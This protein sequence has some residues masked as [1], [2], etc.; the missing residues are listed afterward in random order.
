MAKIRF[1]VIGVGN[2]GSM[3]AENLFSGKIKGAELAAVC[4]IDPEK[5]QKAAQQYGVLSFGDYREL[6]RSQAVDAVIVSVPH[7]LHPEI[8]I[9]AMKAGLHV[10]TE[11]P[12][13]VRVGDV[14]KMNREAA[15]HDTVFAIMFNQR[16]N[17]LFQKAKALV[18]SG[19]LGEKRRLTWIITNWYR[20]ES[21]YRSGSW[22]A[23]WRGEG[24]G[25]LMNQAPHN[26][27]LWQ[28]IFGMPR[29]IRAVVKEGRYHDITVEDYAAI[30]GDYDNGAEAQFITTTGEYPGTNRLEIVLSR[31]KIVIEEGKL[32]CWRLSEDADAVSKS[33]PLGMP[34]IPYTYEEYTQDAPE[35][36]H[37]GI[38]NNVCEAILTGKALIAKGEEGIHQIML[39]NAAYL[40]AWTDKTVTLP[41]DGKRFCRYHNQKRKSEGEKSVCDR[42]S[43]ED[44]LCRWQVNW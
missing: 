14:E 5:R 44:A 11:K 36:A 42:E 20:T 26:L 31:G 33:S 10:V 15:K 21:Y 16:T 41:L 3:H 8:A 28:W 2:I 29:Q 22:R 13:G 1:G 35:S 32:K 9:A 4:D 38:L 7:Y 19:E 27:D 25:V 18:E 40:S 34:R 24:G 30:Y 23:T 43:S 6:L 17:P 12:A 39:T 37:I